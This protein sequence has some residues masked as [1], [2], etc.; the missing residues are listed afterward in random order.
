MSTLLPQTKHK[1]YI[2]LSKKHLSFLSLCT[3]S[4]TWYLMLWTKLLTDLAL[5][6]KTRS[7]IYGIWIPRSKFK[8]NCS[9][10]SPFTLSLPFILPRFDVPANM[11]PSQNLGPDVFRGSA[12]KK[13]V[14]QVMSK[15]MFH[16]AR[17]SFVISFP[18]KASQVI[19]FALGGQMLDHIRSFQ[20]FF[21]KSPLRVLYA[22]LM[23]NLPL[24]S[25]VV[26]VPNRGY[27]FLIEKIF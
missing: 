27:N 26:Q 24:S 22:L 18:H 7:S 8:S 1:L 23:E 17:I 4:R 20:G 25:T 19:N 14:L 9:C 12:P 2:S 6:L 3:L 15:L 13:Q 10:C 16:L 11:Q 5:L 21:S